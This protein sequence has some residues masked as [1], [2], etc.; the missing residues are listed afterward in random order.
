MQSLHRQLQREPG[1][2][3]LTK[4]SMRSMRNMR[5]SMS[6]GDHGESMR[7]VARVRVVAS[8]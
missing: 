4:R 7:V 2:E 8:G 5:G 3:P 1:W 6:K